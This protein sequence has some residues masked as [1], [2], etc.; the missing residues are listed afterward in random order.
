MRDARLASDRDQPLGDALVLC[1]ATRD[2]RARAERARAGHAGLVA[3]RI[4]VGVGHVE[5]DREVGLGG[6]GRRART[7]VRGLLAHRRHGDDLGLQ[8]AGCCGAARRLEHDQRAEPVVERAGCEPQ[9]AQLDRHRGHDDGIADLHGPAGIG[10]VARPDVDPEIVHER[11]AL[12]I[13]LA[14]EVAGGLSDHTRHLTPGR[15]H[16]HALAHQHR[17]IPRADLTH[18]QHARRVDVLDDQAD[19]VD[20]ADERDARA[21]AGVDRRERVAQ[22]VAANLGELRGCAPPDLCRRPFVARGPDRAQQTVQQDARP[23]V[24]ALLRHAQ[25]DS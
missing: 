12:A 15:H 2:R 5:R 1:C 3:V 7:G 10:L 13:L 21:P 20:M 25:K 16:G 24:D 6:E 11:H 14:Q 4:V 22:R 19:L 9:P 23:R 8:V 18:E 17:R